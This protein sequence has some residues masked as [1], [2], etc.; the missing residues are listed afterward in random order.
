MTPSE[1]GPVRSVCIV[2]LSAIGDAVHVLPV[3]NALK[4]AWPDVRISWI[5]QRTPRTLV[6]GHPAID[7]L[8]EYDRRRRGLR[9]WTNFADLAHY[10]RGQ[11][12]DLA[13]ALQVYLKA[14]IIIGLLPAKRKLGFDSARARW[15]LDLHK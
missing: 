1:N 13:L 3:A 11:D 15:Q 12:F 4:R 14:G 10:V 5:I 8:I 7:E 9:S 2:M 6:E